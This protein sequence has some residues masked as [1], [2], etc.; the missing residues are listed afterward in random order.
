MARPSAV[1]RACHPFVRF[2]KPSGFYA[3]CAAASRTAGARSTTERLQSDS[4]RFSEKS[5]SDG[6]VEFAAPYAIRGRAAGP[7]RSGIASDWAQ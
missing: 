3:A 2:L 1:E 5:L 7:S 4:E 6:S